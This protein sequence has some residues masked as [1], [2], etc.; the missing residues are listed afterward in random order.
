MNYSE[1]QKATCVNSYSRTRTPTKVQR[2]FIAEYRRN[3]S[4]P[5]IKTIRKWYTVFQENGSVETPEEK[6]EKMGPKIVTN[7]FDRDPKQSLRRISKKLEIRYGSVQ[8]VMKS[9]G[10][11]P[12]MANI[13]QE[14][15]PNYYSTRVTFTESTPDKIKKTHPS[16]PRFCY[17]QAML[18]FIVI[19]LLIT[20]NAQ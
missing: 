3:E 19:S 4:A 8:N 16:S 15:H 18:C 20:P 10:K 11:K 17:S 1:E 6:T 5:S 13:V 14:L 7:E 2:L 12:Y 9:S